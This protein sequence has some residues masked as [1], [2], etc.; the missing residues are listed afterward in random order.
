[1]EEK[2]SSQILK[3]KNSS[4]K[5]IAFYKTLMGYRKLILNITC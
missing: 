4:S 5:E 1:M 3:E 2:Y